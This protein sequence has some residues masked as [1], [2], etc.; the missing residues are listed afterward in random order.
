M[1]SDRERLARTFDTAA[2]LYDKA[3]PGYP[4]ALFDDLVGLAGI[5][6]G[7]RV[8]EIGCGTGK[9]TVPLARRGF[10]VLTL[11][12]G[13][14]LATVARRNLARFPLA[15]VRTTR[16][17]DWP[18]EPGAFDLVVAATSFP[19]AD[20]AV[21]YEKTA[22]ALRPGGCAAV[23]WHVGIKGPE[24]DRAEERVLPLYRRI[25]PEIADVPPPPTA[26]EVSFDFDP[27][28]IDSG[29]FEPVA[30][31]HYPVVH[32]YT[33]GQYLDLLRTF[34]N[35]IA[36]PEAKRTALLDAIAAL[37]DGELGGRIRRHSVVVLQ[38]L[39]RR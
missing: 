2:E 16:F 7:G 39:R 37:I 12:P 4:E 18:V 13:A 28:F 33:S 14:N 26:G 9:A 32:T 21:R 19:W 17:E 5:P 31:R 23:F 15:E 29:H 36:L 24:G 35:H 10:R 6:E 34:S 30:V 38:V 25:T 8:L 22:E 3:R 1:T 11:E 20:P 27:G